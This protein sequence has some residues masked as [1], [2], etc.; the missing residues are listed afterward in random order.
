MACVVNVERGCYIT[1]S[2]DCVDDC[3]PGTRFDEASDARG[4]P[5]VRIL[6]WAV[7]IVEQDILRVERHEVSVLVSQVASSRP[8][9]N[10]FVR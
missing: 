3:L 2:Y 9:E 4:H 6:K 1:P 8:N 7:I 10:D 5:R